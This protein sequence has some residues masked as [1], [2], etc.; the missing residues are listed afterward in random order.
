[1]AVVEIAVAELEGVI[2]EGVLVT[3]VFGVLELEALEAWLILQMDCAGALV[4]LLHLHEDGD[5]SR[6]MLVAVAF[7][8]V[9]SSDHSHL[10]IWQ[11]MRSLVA[12]LHQ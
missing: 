8:E 7:V 5:S 10:S 11:E 3:F 12:L 2:I 9:L 6:R 4:E 1:M